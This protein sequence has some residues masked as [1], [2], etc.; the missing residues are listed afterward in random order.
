M[1]IGPPYDCRV[2]FDDRTDLIVFYCIRRP[3]TPT[4]TFEARVFQ[5]FFPFS[6]F[7]SFSSFL[8]PVFQ[9]ESARFETTLETFPGIEGVYFYQRDCDDSFRNLSFPSSLFSFSPNFFFAKSF[10]PRLRNSIDKLVNP[11]PC[12]RLILRNPFR[13]ILLTEGTGNP[14]FRYVL[15]PF[16]N[17]ANLVPIFASSSRFPLF[18]ARPQF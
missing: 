9:T 13:R 8:L 12:I 5:F 7:F 2:T 16:P 17:A 14:R 11:F 6:S 3:T 15:L 18:F 4:G 10:S 1:V